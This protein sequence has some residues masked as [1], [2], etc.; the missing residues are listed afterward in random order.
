MHVVK[1]TNK[2]EVEVTIML[3]IGCNQTISAIFSFYASGRGAGPD[4]LY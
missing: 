4:C 3:S 2:F 1:R